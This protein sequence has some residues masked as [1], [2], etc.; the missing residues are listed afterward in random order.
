MESGFKRRKI[1]KA[2]FGFFQQL[3]FP[4]NFLSNG[5]HFE[6]PVYEDFDGKKRPVVMAKIELDVAED[7]H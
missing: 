6:A 1:G 3:S 2:N 4:P 7:I 5:C